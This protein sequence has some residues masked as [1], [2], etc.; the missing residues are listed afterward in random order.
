MVLGQYSCTNQGSDP[1][2]DAANVVDVAAACSCNCLQESY[3][4]QYIVKYRLHAT[5]RYKFRCL[6]CAF[7]FP[8]QN[9][10]KMALSQALL[11]L[12][13]YVPKVCAEGSTDSKLLAN[14]FG[15]KNVFCFLSV[16]SVLA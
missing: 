10:C 11:Q 3:R 1:E 7:A 16:Y 13:T 2:I 9:Y 5:Y 12:Y 6:Q 8:C 14:V 15:D 4:N